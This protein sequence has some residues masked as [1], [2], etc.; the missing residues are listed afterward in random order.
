MEEWKEY[1]LK[2]VTTILGDG[3]HGTPKYDKNGNVFFIN[4]NN[5]VDGK[6][7]IKDSTKR[8]SED[9]ANK[10]RR[11]LNHRTILV[12]INGTIGNVAKY[13]GETCILGKSA[14]YFNVAEDFDLDFIYYVVA[15][16]QFRNTITRLATG[17]TI[18]N[19]SLET[20]RNYSFV[21]PSIN[22]QKSIS[23]MLSSLDNKIELNH[24][25]NDN[26]EQQAQA[27]FK[28]WFVD[29]EPFKDGEFVNSEF[30]M[31]PKGWRIGVLSDIIEILSGFAFK[32][33]TFEIEG[34]Y[35]LI[36][37]KAVQDGY[38]DLNGADSINDVPI[39]VPIHCF[40]KKKDILLSLTGNVGR[41]CLVNSDN[42]LLNQRVAKIEPKKTKDWA[43]T[44]ILFRLADTK[45][46][47]ET[48]S[49]GTA[50][51]N[52]SPIE[53]ANMPILIPTREVMDAFSVCATP[54]VNYSMVLTIEAEKLAQHRDTLLPKLMSGELKINDLNS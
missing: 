46:Y 33:N 52:L 47:L 34:K 40:L 50:Q 38:L 42:L 37:I 29:F 39:K 12:S 22:G 9:E 36:T 1:K 8:V 26:L 48:I 18:K 3:L 16:K 24:R 2:D 41:C 10:Y 20:M 25:I 23:S 28:S 5:L 19:V 15:S 13:K 44:Y 49:R 6:I 21:A 51:A 7:E 45:T 27:L 32:S 31:I 30:G 35:K 43:Y 17:T 53:T 11:N 54:L 14:C 4:G